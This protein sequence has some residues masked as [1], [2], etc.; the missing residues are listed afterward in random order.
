MPSQKLLLYAVM[1]VIR[2]REKVLTLYQK[3]GRAN[4]S[5]LGLSLLDS[6]SQKEGRPLLSSPSRFWLSS[7]SWL[8]HG[9]NTADLQGSRRPI[10][11]WQHPVDCMIAN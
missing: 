5:L 9:P 7:E 3:A 6:Q 2:Q 11:I 4:W 10:R 1:K 8:P